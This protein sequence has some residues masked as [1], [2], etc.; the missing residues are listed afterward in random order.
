MKVTD[1]EIIEAIQD[2]LLAFDG[3]QYPSL[4]KLGPAPSRSL[5]DLAA[6]ADRTARAAEARACVPAVRKLI[7]QAAK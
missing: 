6:R 5:S 7:G 4:A 1:Q 2:A 3:D